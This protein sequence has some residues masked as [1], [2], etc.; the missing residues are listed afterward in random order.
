MKCSAAQFSAVN[1]IVVEF[2]VVHFFLKLSA[3]YSRVDIAVYSTVYSTFSRSVYSKEKIIV[4]S[5]VY[6]SV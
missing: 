2:I 6:I 4:Y 3:V 5:I 1:F